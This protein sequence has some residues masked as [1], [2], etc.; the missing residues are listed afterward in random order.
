[1]KKIRMMV[2]K[3]ASRMNSWPKSLQKIM[4]IMESRDRWHLFLYVS[5]RSTLLKWTKCPLFFCGFTYPGSCENRKSV[6]CHLKNIGTLVVVRVYVHQFLILS[7]LT[8]FLVIF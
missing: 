5:V 6:E 4:G 8:Y 3:R 7:S 2:M 1:M